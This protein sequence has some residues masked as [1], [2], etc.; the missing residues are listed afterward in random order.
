[1]LLTNQGTM[2]GEFLFSAREDEELIH[3][4]EDYII[5]DTLSNLTTAIY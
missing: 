5:W 4:G 3:Q 2:L 1:M